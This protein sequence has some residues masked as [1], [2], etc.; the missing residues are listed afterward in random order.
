MFLAGSGVVV[1]K[2]LQDCSLTVQ[3]NES[4]LQTL[5]HQLQTTHSAEQNT[6]TDAQTTHNAAE[7]THH[8]DTPVCFT[9]DKLRVLQKAQV[10]RFHWVLKIFFHQRMVETIMS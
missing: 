7:T 10:G 9:V 1:D 3:D 6:H 8:A 5:L 4:V 2:L